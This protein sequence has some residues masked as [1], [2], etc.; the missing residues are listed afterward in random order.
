MKKNLAPFRLDS[1][2]ASHHPAPEL[3]PARR[4]FLK[5]SSLLALSAALGTQIPFGRFFPDG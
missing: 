2:S 3:E 5:G 4:K 1:A